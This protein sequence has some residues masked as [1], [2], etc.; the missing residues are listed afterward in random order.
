MQ[1]RHW[2]FRVAAYLYFGMAALMLLALVLAPWLANRPYTLAVYLVGA[3]LASVP[4]ALGI[5]SNRAYR[6]G[7]VPSRLQIAVSAAP[8]SLG[9]LSQNLVVSAVLLVPLLFV[10]AGWH[11]SQE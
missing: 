10:A 3:A 8:M 1:R 2:A 6:G 7:V 4:L 9:P 5:W 11:A